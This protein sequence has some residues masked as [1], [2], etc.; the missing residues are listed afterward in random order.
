M[1]NFDFVRNLCFQS[2]FPHHG[3]GHV[4]LSSINVEYPS[5]GAYHPTGLK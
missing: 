3:G 1:N 5:L 2:S 4:L